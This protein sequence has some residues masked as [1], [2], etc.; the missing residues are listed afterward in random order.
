MQ[1]MAMYE[2]VARTCGRWKGEGQTVTGQ[3][4]PTITGGRLG[5]VLSG[6]KDFGGKEPAPT[7]SVMPNQLSEI[8]QYQ[9]VSMNDFIVVLA[10]KTG[11][12]LRCF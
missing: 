4:V 2:T 9:I 5:T 7:P 12:D 1:Q 3:A 6:I 8:L 10:A 11:L